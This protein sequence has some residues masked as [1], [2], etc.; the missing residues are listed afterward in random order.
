[1]SPSAGSGL[2]GASHTVRNS[3]MNS[4]QR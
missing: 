2:A 1:L 3:Q 4:N